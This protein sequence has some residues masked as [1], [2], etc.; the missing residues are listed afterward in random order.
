MVES[1]CSMMALVDLS[2]TL[3]NGSVKA[4]VHHWN[5]KISQLMTGSPE[6]YLHTH[7]NHSLVF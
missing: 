2:A 4:L 7:K 1:N 6:H 5:R 3:A